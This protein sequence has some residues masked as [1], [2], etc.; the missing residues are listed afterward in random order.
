MNR[1]VAGY[2]L[3]AATLSVVAPAV[4]ADRALRPRGNPDV[5]PARMAI[6]DA[7]ENIRL[8][9]FQLSQDGTRLVTSHGDG[10]IRV[11]TFPSGELLHRLALQ[12]EYWSNDKTVR[13]A[14]AGDG[15]TLA[16]A[17]DGWLRLWNIATGEEKAAIRTGK[18]SAKGDLDK[19]LAGGGPDREAIWRLSH[20]GRILANGQGWS[21]DGLGVVRRWDAPPETGKAR[22]GV[23]RYDAKSSPPLLTDDGRGAWLADA[24]GR[25]TYWDLATRELTRTIEL[26]EPLPRDWLRQALGR[27]FDLTGGPD[28]EFLALSR[29]GVHIGR[30]EQKDVVGTW[31]RPG[32]LDITINHV[33]HVDVRHE[34]LLARA[35]PTLWLKNRM[36]ET[37]R[38]LE[39]DE[40]GGHI[41]TYGFAR[42][43]DAVWAVVSGEWAEVAEKDGSESL[44]L[45][46]KSRDWAPARLPSRALGIDVAR[47]SGTTAFLKADHLDVCLPG[48]A[49]RRIECAEVKGEWPHLSA[50]GAWVALAMKGRTWVWRTST[51]ERVGDFEGWFDCF[52]EGGNLQTRCWGYPEFEN[53]Y[54]LWHLPDGRELARLDPDT[55]FI[56]HR[57]VASWAISPD[58]RFVATGGG[59]GEIALWDPGDL[60]P[61]KSPL[62]AEWQAHRGFVTTLVFSPDGR[63]LY[64]GSSDKTIRAWGATSRELLRTFPAPEAVHQLWPLQDGRSVLVGD[65]RGVWRLSIQENAK[66]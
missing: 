15:T 12:H 10:V 44:V 24:H 61:D 37:L 50:D 1:F 30:L 41:R 66:E 8:S 46:D 63:T 52:T 13:M 36:G 23:L 57:V 9:S 7:T 5:A 45:W 3:W 27:C 26:G 25:V 16:T 48:Q 42:K 18:P 55:F 32:S 20:G 43:G 34:R 2:L 40:A 28:G 19:L 51:G 38:I 14:L 54:R 31:Q 62:V 11:W 4:S 33:R 64:S 29:S 60:A 65:H 53:R 59:S 49:V 22:L 35:G 6:P 17:G 39:L 21:L 58:G 47:D 56:G